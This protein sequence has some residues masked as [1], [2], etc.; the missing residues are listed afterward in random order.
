MD[1]IYK[2]IIAATPAKVATNTLT[3]KVV[4]LDLSSSPPPFPAVP[5]PLVLDSAVSFFPAQVKSSPLITP[6][7]LRSVNSL[8]EISSVDWRLKP[9]RT[10]SS[11]SKV[12]LGWSVST[13]VYILGHQKLLTW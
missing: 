13:H 3:P 6:E 7:L 9:P 12:T 10:S 8:Q 4:A 5:R 1:Y 2:A 11:E